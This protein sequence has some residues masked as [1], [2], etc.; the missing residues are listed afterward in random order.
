MDACPAPPDPALRT[1]L[2]AIWQRLASATHDRAAGWR[3]PALASVDETGAPRV[4]T[5]VLRGADPAAPA[6]VLHTDARS[7]KAAE[8]AHQARV[9]LVFWDPAIGT[10]LRIEGEAAIIADPAT[11]ATLPPPARRLYAVDPAPGTPIEAPGAF[12]ETDPARC[13]RVLR[14]VPRRLEWLDI[15][16]PHRR[17]RFDLAGGRACWLVP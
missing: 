16:L 11:F 15:S 10:Q 4:R 9:A 7:A 2:D 3:H 17:A 12:G 13:F 6:L 14:V 1:L 5:L 8:I